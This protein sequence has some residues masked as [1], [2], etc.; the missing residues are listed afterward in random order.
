MNAKR[1]MATALCVLGAA[2]PALAA[3]GEGEGLGLWTILFLGFGALVIAMQ[4]VPAV[5]MFVSMLRGLFRAAPEEAEAA[6]KSG[7]A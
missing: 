3:G 5:V 4:A 2:A 7:K 1:S 6:G